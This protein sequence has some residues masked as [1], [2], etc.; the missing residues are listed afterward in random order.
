MKIVF[1]MRHAGALRNFASTV[2]E[3]ARRGHRIHLIFMRR[4]K[5]GES[6]LLHELVSAY[7]AITRTEPHD[8]ISRPWTA[9]ART[10]RAVGD[11]T[12]YRAPAYED[13]HALRDRAARHLPPSIRRRLES[14]AFRTRAA[15][16]VLTYVLRLVER[17]VPVDPF[18]LE[19]VKRQAPDLL[20]VTP[21]VDFGSA[22]E[23]YVKA[24][25]A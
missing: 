11:Y 8:R 25:R 3:L 1:S 24:A 15:L 6:R 14:P 17:A 9:L 16:A 10:I 20:L 23:E 13:A 21:L 2:E 18:V 19:A 12:R 5:L 4:D 7:P 22:Q